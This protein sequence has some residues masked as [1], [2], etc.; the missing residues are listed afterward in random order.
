M[1][2]QNELSNCVVVFIKKKKKRET[3]KDV[4][5][6]VNQKNC[7]I[8]AKQLIVK[9]LSKKR[10]VVIRI[11][12]SHISIVIFFNLISVRFLFM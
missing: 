8:Q 9:I 12:K 1:L 7:K 2:K 3:L 5:Q 6:E 11:E 4:Y 10:M